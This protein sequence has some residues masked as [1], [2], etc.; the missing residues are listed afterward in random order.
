MKIQK[1][2]KMK[3]KILIVDDEENIRFAFEMMLVEEGYEVITASNF[4]EAIALL[5][6]D[7]PDLVITDI[8]LGGHTGVDLLAEIKNQKL[9]CP[10]IMITGEPNIESSANAVRL[11]A[12]DYVPKPIRRETLLRI[13]SHGIT[14]KKLLDN[15]LYLEKENL[16]VRKNMEAIFASLNDGIITVDDHLCIVEA[17]KAVE[18]ICSLPV[19]DILGQEFEKKL[20]HCNGACLNVLKKTLRTKE[21]VSDIQIECRHSNT[22]NQIVRLTS[23]PLK[24]DGINFSGAVLVIKNITKLATLEKKLEE[25][26][27]FHQII[28]KS[29]K[30][31]DIYTLLENISETDSTIL[32]TGDTGTGKELIANA[33]HHHSPRQGKAMVKVNCSALSESLLESE[34]F[35]HVKGAFTGAVKDKKGRFE[36]ANGGTI[37]L[38]EIGDISPLIQLKLLRVL[39]EKEFERVGDSTTLKTDVRILA[40]TNHDLKE[41]A[42]HGEFRKD[43]YYRI[44][45]V[46]IPLPS[47]KNRREDIPI[48]ANHF[49]KKFNLRFKKNISG[50]S[51]EVINAFMNYNWPGN[52]RELE[53]AIEHGFVLCQEDIM[54]FDHLPIELRE[55]DLTHKTFHS[56][57]VVITKI[58]IQNALIKTD[59][60]KSK[61]ARLLGMGRRTIYRKIEEFELVRPLDEI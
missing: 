19:K 36:L 29:S 2:K 27:Q 42:D 15:K 51:N 39:Q 52:I 3:S 23:T 32:I 17:N 49:L 55:L 61:A 33:I 25:R 53:H 10:V 21:T 48:L 8:I 24:S 7:P 18:T 40:A 38:D 60:N 5:S 30:M 28:G 13:T 59:W 46:D 58:D 54:L 1:K 44:K 20:T 31:Q 50:Y 45:V 11:G 43:L 12:F 16:R 37:F 6:Q 9:N 57:K 34:L 35:G 22:Q 56:E 47:L 26:Q 14:H 41:K 4:N